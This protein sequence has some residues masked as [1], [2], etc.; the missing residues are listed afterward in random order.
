MDFPSSSSAFSPPLALLACLLLASLSWSSVR[1]RRRTR[2]RPLPPGPPRLPVVGNL[3]NHPRVKRWVPYHELCSR[4]GDVLY[5]SVMGQSILVLDSARAVHEL[6]EKKAANTSDRT[7]SPMIELSG[8]SLNFGFM[9][10]GQRW[11]RHRRAF[12]QHFNQGAAVAYWPAQRASA[13]QFLWKLLRDASRFREHIRYT[14]AGVI[15][16]VGFDIDVGDEDDRYVAAVDAALEGPVQGL[17]PGTF[18]VDFLPFLRYVPTWFPGATSQRLWAKWQA[19]AE[20]LKNLPYDHVK[21]AL[22]QASN[23]EEPRSII[24][25]LIQQITAV[26]PGA[27]HE[28]EEIV[29]NVGAITF[30]AGLDT[31]YITTL[32][33]FLAMTMHPA[34]LKKA[35]AELDRVV[36]PDRLPDFSD[37]DALVYVN[38][39]VKETLRWHPV[40][41][42][43]LPHCTVEDDELDGYFVPAGTVVIPNIWACMRDPEMYDE[44]EEF[45]PERFIHDGKLD[46]AVR[47]PAA[48]VFGFGRRICPGR[49]FAQAGLFITVASVL[50]VFDITSPL[51]DHG[52]PVQ[53]THGME[54]GLSSHLS[55]YRCTITA[56]SAEA[57][58]LILAHTRQS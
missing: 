28:E 50:H 56:R 2:G 33:V 44:P 12:W 55:D 7:Q 31:V 11:R 58:A 45:R 18:L 40:L 8:S 5:F 10:Y 51:D 9:P 47:D 27:R 4:Y 36:G 19:A 24:G 17:V 32:A 14:Y 42:L 26:E 25:K 16:K 20:T 21:A 6:L 53:I 41:P 15:L 3:F 39:I 29:K 23:D 54:D 57:E 49:Y 34:V 13:H 52:R 30:E 22:D 48:L 37:Q 43:G 1:W 38:A 35:H 46:P